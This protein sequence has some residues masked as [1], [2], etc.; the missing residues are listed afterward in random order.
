M[1]LACWQCDML[2]M[3]EL[4]IALSV[5]NINHQ[6]YMYFSFLGIKQCAYCDL[7]DSGRRIKGMRWKC[8]EC[9]NFDLCTSC[10]MSAEDEH[11]DH[12]FHRITEP[13][14]RYYKNIHKQ[15]FSLFRFQ[16]LYLVHHF[17][18]RSLK[19]IELHSTSTSTYVQFAFLIEHSQ[20]DRLPI[21][22]D[23]SITF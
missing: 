18:C 2:L 10:Y 14:K 17:F 15:Q 3:K 1:T 9:P 8:S 12:I 6:Q 22:N 21:Y 5:P 4:R 7:C 13:T 11:V 19:R 16:G 23:L 20:P